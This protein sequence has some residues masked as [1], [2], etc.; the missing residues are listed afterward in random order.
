MTNPDKKRS[1]PVPAEPPPH[2]GHEGHTQQN[3]STM[4][5]AMQYAGQGF[6][7][8]PCKGKIPLTDHGKDDATK[9][10]AIIKAWWKK[11]PKANVAI[12][13]ER[14]GLFALDAD[15]PDSWERMKADHGGTANT[16]PIQITPHG[17]KHIIWLWP[18][19]LE[20]PAKVDAFPDLGYPG[21]D[22]R[23]RSY[24]VMAPSQIDR[25]PYTWLPDHGPDSQIYPPPEWLIELIR[26]LRTPAKGPAKTGPAFAN[27]DRTEWAR[28]LLDQLAPS[29]CSNYWD[30][31]RVGMALSELGEAGLSLWDSW[32]QKCPEKYKGF[33]DCASR[34]E[35]LVP[36]KGISIG[37]LYHWARE[38]SPA[39][40]RVTIPP[41]PDI[42]PKED[43][44]PE[45]K[46]EK[47]GTMET[48]LPDLS[49]V[50][51]PDLPK[52][53]RLTDKELAQ[54][55]YSG[56]WI[57]SYA[58]FAKQALPMT[59]PEHNR[60][61]AYEV[62]STAIARRV[63]WRISTEEI[64]TNLYGLLMAASGD[65]KSG[66]P[67]LAHK[68][69]RSAKLDPL[70]LPGY[71]SPQGF[72]QE[73]I[74]KPGDLQ[75]EYN[76]QLREAQ[77]LRKVYS[78]QRL[79]LLDEVSILFEWFG[80]SSM[81]GMKQMI[82]RLFDC[83]PVEGETT[84]GRGNGIARNIYLNICGISTQTDMAPFFKQ[85]EH[86]GNGVW[87]RFA[88]VTPTWEKPPYICFPPELALPAAITEPLEKLFNKLPKP[89]EGELPALSISIPQNVFDRWRA[90]DKAVRYDLVYS[91][92][93][94]NRYKSNYKRFPMLAM[95]HAMIAA[96]LEWIDSAAATPVMEL[97]HLYLGMIEAE[98]YR[99]S[100]HRL[101]EIPNREGQEESLEAKILRLC[102]ALGSGIVITE[103]EIAIAVNLT[104][105]DERYK[106]TKQLEQM[107]K[108]GLIVKKEKVERHTKTGRSTKVDGYCRA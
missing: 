43:I 102:P 106:L 45:N 10:P 44:L 80:Q 67:R 87:S 48:A 26:G 34:W 86:W 88:F 3:Y 11:W 1:D 104:D 61:L 31:I 39:P 23:S 84:V 52:E 25:K 16:G 15:Q 77:R 59:P 90:Y 73:L 35:K 47:P 78:A 46:N 66:G 37:S 103:R 94:S 63:V 91:G 55:E 42:Q 40:A 85:A 99:A 21:L 70:T 71:M 68:V 51:I 9:D 75:D 72:L 108:D 53:A 93:L 29:R 101:L 96:I 36:D 27:T 76:D 38:D 50:N 82:L 79:L 12:N 54:A 105:S 30:W 18:E 89:Q 8:L 19:G 95:K 13:L 98:S 97:K 65:S 7:V 5:A 49:L 107:V 60:F 24:I 100:I 33:S 69:L 17:G 58:A 2:N 56:N 32:S 28:S 83:P 41:E 4:E 92:T 81:A 14:S 64:Y 57:D 74:G 22:L 20:I 6:Y 62:A